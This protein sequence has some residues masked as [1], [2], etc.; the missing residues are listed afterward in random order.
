MPFPKSG[1]WIVRLVVVGA[2]A[3]APTAATTASAR[4]RRGNLRMIDMGSSSFAGSQG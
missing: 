1:G 4:I 2:L 3:Q